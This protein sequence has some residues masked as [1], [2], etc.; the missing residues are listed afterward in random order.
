M[1]GSNAPSLQRVD[2]GLP[3]GEN[4]L[5]LRE[6]GRVFQKRS[7][8]NKLQLNHTIS[9]RNAQEEFGIERFPAHPRRAIVGEGLAP[10]G[11]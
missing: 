9:S 4:R 8:F 1:D 6:N 2:D 11:S 5:I 7:T 10:P 3:E